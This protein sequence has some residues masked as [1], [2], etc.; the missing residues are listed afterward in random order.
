M[1]R[2]LISL[3]IGITMMAIGGTMMFFE[4]KDYTAV[5]ACELY[6]KHFYSSVNTFDISKKDLNIYMGRSYVDYEFVIDESYGDKVKIEAPDYIDQTVSE[7]EYY[8]EGYNDRH[9]EAEAG[10]NTFTNAIDIIIEG[11]KEHKLYSCNGT[12]VIRI[13]CSSKAKAHIN[14]N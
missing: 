12:R 10:W 9:Y 14:I 7:H 1:K 2:F 13:T 11:L 3:I 6:D 8:V 4:V 5:N